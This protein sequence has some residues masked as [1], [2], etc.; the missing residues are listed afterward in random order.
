MIAA[1]A[2]AG[3]PLGGAGTSTASFVRT[4][5]AFA[6]FSASSRSRTVGSPLSDA[7]IRGSAVDAGSLDGILR[8]TLQTPKNVTDSDALSTLDDATESVI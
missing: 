5:A 8:R 4:T 3:S 2:A 7:A 6:F 1:D